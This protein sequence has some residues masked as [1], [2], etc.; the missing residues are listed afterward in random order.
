MLRRRDPQQATGDLTEVASHRLLGVLPLH[1]GH[2]ILGV[3]D[4]VAGDEVIEATG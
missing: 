1:K 2:E 4:G 3:R